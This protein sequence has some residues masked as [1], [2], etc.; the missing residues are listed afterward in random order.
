MTE[1]EERTEA[2]VGV[3]DRGTGGASSSCE[4]AGIVVVGAAEVGAAVVGAAVCVVGAA[5]VGAA[6]AGANVEI[7]AASFCPPPL[8]KNTWP[9]CTA[10]KSEV[11]LSNEDGNGIPSNV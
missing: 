2:A 6:V 11:V 7:I 10:Y 9:L 1:S 3:S 4:V 8:T 5:V